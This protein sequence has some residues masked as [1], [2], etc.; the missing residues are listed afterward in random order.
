[1]IPLFGQH[2]ADDGDVLH[3]LGNLRQPLGDLNA[4]HA[5]IDGLRFPAVFVAGLGREGFKLARPTAHEEHNAC[6]AAGPQLVSLAGDQFLPTQRARGDSGQRHAVKKVAATNDAIAV[7]PHAH[8]MLPKVHACS[9][10][11]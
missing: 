1:M 10:C 11:G 8:V 5:G 3:H 6:H 4:R 7:D 2:R 9:L